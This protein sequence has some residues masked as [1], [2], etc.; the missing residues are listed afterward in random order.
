M[1]GT[2]TMTIVTTGMGMTTTTR[3]VMT[4][5]GMTT[6]MMTMRK[7]EGASAERFPEQ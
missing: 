7:K 5:T 3:I 6:T 1:N 2:T 4:G